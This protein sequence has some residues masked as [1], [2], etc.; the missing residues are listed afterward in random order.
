MIRTGNYIE[1]ALWILMAVVGGV[2]AVQG[3]GTARRRWW[4]V[5]AA[6]ALFGLSDVVEARTGAW[7]RPWWLLVWKAACL[8]AFAGAAVHYF[9]Q[10]RR[11]AGRS[12]DETPS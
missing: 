3:V 7:W 8:A 5:A 10:K 11:I 12:V 9:R 4:L 2:Y 1:A 6:L